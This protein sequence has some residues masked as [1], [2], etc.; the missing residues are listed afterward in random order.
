MQRAALVGALIGA[1]Y[2]GT[3]YAQEAQP[4]PE[5]IKAAAEEFDRGRRAYLAK[6]FEQ[7]AVHF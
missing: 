2:A 6:D 1:M 4:S 7:A 3:A 5:R